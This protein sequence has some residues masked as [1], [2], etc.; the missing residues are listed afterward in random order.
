M[1]H[2]DN[3][4]LVNT[5]PALEVPGAT[6]HYEAVGEG[7]M[8]LAIHGGGGEGQIWRAFSEELKH[9]YTVVFYD[10]TSFIVH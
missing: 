1:E 4:D 3:L 7:P 2:L 10:R 8:L 9:R 6:L 5:M